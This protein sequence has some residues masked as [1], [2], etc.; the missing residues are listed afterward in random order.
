MPELDFAALREQLESGARP[1]EFGEIRRRRT[2]RTRRIAV[3][4]TAV[5]TVLAVTAGTLAVGRPWANPP[6]VHPTPTATGVPKPAPSDSPQP[7]PTVTDSAVVP[8]AGPS[9]LSVAAV[10]ATELLGITSTCVNPCPTDLPTYE[11]HLTRSTNLGVSWSTVGPI[12]QVKSPDSVQ[13]LVAD[14]THLWAYA[15]G[16][17]FGSADGGHSWHTWVLGSDAM[18]GGNDVV[19]ARVGSTA[20]FTWG[21]QVW[22]AA[23]GG[24]PRQTTAPLPTGGVNQVVP[25]DANHAY[26]SVMQETVAGAWFET[27]DAGSHWQAAP[28]PCAKV[29]FPASFSTRMAVAPDGSLWVVCASEPGAG[30]QPKDLVVSTDGGSSWVSRG[31]LES[32]GYGTEVYPF[33]STAA[34]RTGGRADLYR[35]TDG[36]HW[37]DLVNLDSNGPEAF[38]AFDA[39]TAV[40]L[41]GAPYP[42]PRLFVTNDGGA[43]WTWHEAP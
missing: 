42:T 13:L 12:A 6:E 15:G 22:I 5:A 14:P 24:Q 37:T 43:H 27:T 40:Y 10:S 36:V 32:T 18:A 26:A 21:R 8:A 17:V 3:V 7:T 9:L 38:S 35:T 2:Q 1:P 28:D 4:A 23:A 11:Y 30:Q 29:R 33:S 25:L 20:W 16:T 39:Q 19:A 31:Q 34:W 41:Y